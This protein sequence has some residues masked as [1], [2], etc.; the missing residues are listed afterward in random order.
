MPLKSTEKNTHLRAKIYQ[1]LAE[2]RQVVV[3]MWHISNEFR[4]EPRVQ[5]YK[6]VLESC[7]NIRR[8]CWK[9]WIAGTS[10]RPLQPSLPAFS[11]L[12]EC[13]HNVTGWSF[14]SQDAVFWHHSGR[15]Y[16]NLEPEY[17]LPPLNCL[18]LEICPKQQEDSL[19]HPQRKGKE[20]E[21]E[22]GVK[23]QSYGG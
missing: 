14:F 3:W 9:M 23:E 22:K 13:G 1:T 17:V 4:F 6:A 21:D 16:W 7:A 5:S 8:L 20:I 15:I 19:K 2:P 11:L 10:L 18:L 12:L